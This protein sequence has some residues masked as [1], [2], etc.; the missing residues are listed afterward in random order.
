VETVL[1]LTGPKH[2]SKNMKCGFLKAMRTQ[3]VA[4][5]AMTPR[6]RPVRTTGL[7]DTA[8]QKSIKVYSK[9]HRSGFYQAIQLL[10]LPAAQLVEALCYK[11]E[12]RWFDSR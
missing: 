2:K 1:Q 4:L 11:P 3:N 7:H 6:N 8:T 5:W 10:R 12:G 9:V